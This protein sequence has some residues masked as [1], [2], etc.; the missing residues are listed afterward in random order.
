M[1]CYLCI[2]N[3]IYTFIY[4]SGECFIFDKYCPVTDNKVTS[5]ARSRPNPVTL[6]CYIVIIIIIYFACYTFSVY[7]V[8]DSIRKSRGIIVYIVTK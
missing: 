3:V 1:A 6:A 4:V 5:N 8:F 7:S 2:R